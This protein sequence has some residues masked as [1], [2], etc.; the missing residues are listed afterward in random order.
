MPRLWT[1]DTRAD[2]ATTAFNTYSSRYQA[3]PI[4][5]AIATGHLGLIRLN[6]VA[7]E[8]GCHLITARNVPAS[9]LIGPLVEDEPVFPSGEIRYKGQ[10]L[11]LLLVPITYD[12]EELSSALSVSVDAA[13]PLCT[14]D[15]VIN[16]GPLV[17]T[18][19][20]MQTIQIGDLDRADQLL[21][22][23]A[24]RVR[25]KYAFAEVA[26]DYL[27]ANFAFAKYDGLTLTIEAPT[28][29]PFE[30]RRSISRL[31]AL[32]ESYVVI[33]NA[34]ISGSF[35]ARLDLLLAT[36]VAVAAYCS[37]SS[38]FIQDP[39]NDR[40]QQP[41]H[42]NAMTGD[43][44]IG[45]NS[46]GRFIA[47]KLNVDV[48]AGAYSSYG[49][50]VAKRIA[51][52]AA[53]PYRFDA[54]FANVRLIQTDTR[55][56][57]AFRG[58]GVGPLTVMI[59]DQ[60][61]QLAHRLQGSAFN[62]RHSNVISDSARLGNGQPFEAG[63]S[64]LRCLK[65]G[66][67][68]A[69]ELDRLDGELTGSHLRY[70]TGSA[71]FMYGIGNTG[72]PNPAS[73]RLRRLEDGRFIVH[74][75]TVDMGQRSHELL[76][77]IAAAKLGTSVKDIEIISSDTTLSVD[78]GKTS[79]SRTAHYVGSALG[80]AAEQMISVACR[81]IA[82]ATEQPVRWT[83]RN[84]V[85]GSQFEPSKYMSFREAPGLRLEDMDITAS[86]NPQLSDEA[87]FFYPTYAVGCTTARVVLD[88][89]TGKLRVLDV[90]G[91]HDVGDLIDPEGAAG[92]VAGGAAMGTSVALISRES[93]RYSMISATDAPTVSAFFVEDEQPF[94]IRK[95]L[96]E[97]SLVGVAAAIHNAY[98]KIIE[99]EN[100]IV[101]WT[102]HPVQN[103]RLQ[104]LG[105]SR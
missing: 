25:A 75:S 104:A 90:V 63:S 28:Q 6:R 5:S 50:G 34:P 83:G 100:E 85:I 60:I 105:F 44:C 27:G 47:L 103:W 18:A 3:L 77:R 82:A 78:S 65:I 96:G 21:A 51:V 55:P 41:S 97:P 89:E 54:T 91:V 17:L 19:R 98:Q 46:E 42:S 73:I 32:P 84:F 45:T 71:L 30:L 24:H 93:G 81:A 20:T 88:L 14:T 57:S 101:T 62:L 69:N 43:I 53:G 29:A 12:V 95:G 37:R 16:A 56:A 2:S 8:E 40:Q 4:R 7:A 94:K 68:Q 39:S 67:E 79:G 102:P 23:C 66:D 74:T 49:P 61:Q 48:D 38:V 15:E 26:H 76:R 13:E 33:R 31:L 1:I 9:G 72:K 22:Q 99:T 11:G 35:G 10:T 58:F 92:Q 59:E 87:S 64:A 86:Y 80:L 70:S 36:Q 52:H